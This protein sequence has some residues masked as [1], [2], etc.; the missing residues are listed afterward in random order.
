MVVSAIAIGRI[1][2]PLV[3]S[4]P[5]GAGIST[6]RSPR[7]LRSDAWLSGRIAGRGPK[8]TKSPASAEAEAAAAGAA[9]P[10][11]VSATEAH[12]RARFLAY[13]KSGFFRSDGY[14][15]VDR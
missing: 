14:Q 4:V 8:V 6:T 5:A 15:H 1:W 3:G 10:R 13:F 9:K 11:V 12:A 2:P 7:S